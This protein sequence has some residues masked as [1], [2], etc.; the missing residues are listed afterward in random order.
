MISLEPSLFVDATPCIYTKRNTP[1]ISQNRSRVW[2]RWLS[3]YIT[4]NKLISDTAETEQK[5]LLTANIKSYTRYHSTDAKMYD[6][7]RLL[8]DI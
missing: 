4:H 7:E 1:N 2:K 5:L 3:V 6:L 8:S